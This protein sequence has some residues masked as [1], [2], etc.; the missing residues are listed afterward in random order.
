VTSDFQ[1]ITVEGEKLGRAFS[2]IVLQH[3]PNTDFGKFMIVIR[4]QVSEPLW[5]YS[6]FPK[7]VRY[8]INFW[9][10]SRLIERVEGNYLG[11]SNPDQG[12]VIYNSI[13]L[14]S[15]SHPMT[16]LVSLYGDVVL[17][18][19]GSFYNSTSTEILAKGQEDVN[20]FIIPSSAGLVNFVL[21]AAVVILIVLDKTG[22]KRGGITLGK[23]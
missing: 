1:L 20:M 8:C 16:A 3:E 23:K 5:R 22:Y 10:D 19:E 12:R 2:T 9:L 18:V 15:N 7:D 6:V 17:T 21:L 13:L 14:P 11:A 4:T